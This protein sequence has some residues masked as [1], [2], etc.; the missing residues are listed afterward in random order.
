MLAVVCHMCT[1]LI[2]SMDLVLLKGTELAV[3]YRVLQSHVKNI[4]YCEA[5]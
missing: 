3:Y 1:V 4:Y 5:L 2:K